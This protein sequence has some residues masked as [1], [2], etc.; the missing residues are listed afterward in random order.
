MAKKQFRIVKIKQIMPSEGWWEARR[1]LDGEWI[2][3]RLIA[4]G[5]VRGVYETVGVERGIC[6]ASDVEEDRVVG[7]CHRK[8][9][10]TAL[11]QLVIEF[12]DTETGHE[13]VYVK[14]EDFEILGQKLRSDRD[15]ESFR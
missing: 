1:F 3:T 9:D 13:P 10:E 6:E 12:E 14:N 2:F 5:L 4:W 7:L 8:F 11:G 15:L